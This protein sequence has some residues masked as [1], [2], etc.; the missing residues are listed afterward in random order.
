LSLKFNL[1]YTLITKNLDILRGN[2]KNESNNFFCDL[3]FQ[4]H[5]S[6][7]LERSRMFQVCKKCWLVNWNKLLKVRRIINIKG[8][9]TLI[10]LLDVFVRFI[11]SKK[12]KQIYL[13]SQNGKPYFGQLNKK[14]IRVLP[15]LLWQQLMLKKSIIDGN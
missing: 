2:I 7:S 3:P 8:S 1:K 9:S 4:S 13:I 5:Q 10:C 12:C 15:L 11:V 6:T 14:V